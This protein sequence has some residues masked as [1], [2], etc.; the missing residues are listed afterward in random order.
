MIHMKKDMAESYKSMALSGTVVVPGDKS[1]SH[2]AL[3]LGAMAQGI[4]KINGL[5]ESADVLATLEAVKCLGA[6]VQRLVSGQWQVHGVGQSG[7]VSPQKPIECGN[8]GTAVRLLMGAA[9]G[10]ALEAEFAGDISL[11]ARP[12]DRVLVPLQ[13]M[14]VRTRTWREARLPVRLFSNGCLSPIKYNIPHPSAQVKSAILLA[15]LHAQ[16]RSQICE[17]VL[18]R[19]HTENM[20]TAFGVTVERESVGAGQRV[21]VTGCSETKACLQATHVVVPGDPSSAAFAI[22]AALIVPGSEVTV[23]NV[24]MNPTRIGL[25]TCLKEMGANLRICRMRQSGGEPVA[26]I[27]VRHSALKAIN[28]PAM[29]APSMID[30]YPV[31][32]VASAY[33]HGTTVMNGLAELRVKETDRIAATAALLRVNGCV[34]EDSAES[35]AVTGGKVRGGGY[36]ITHHDHRIAMSALVLGLAAEHPVRIDDYGMIATS[37]PNFF[38]LMTDMNACIKCL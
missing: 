35:L 25:L 22:V 24:M 1:I 17:A 6:Q 14:G 26:D 16:G 37:F 27:E 2:R 36:V 3:I 38:T 15:A 30:E 33:A 4:T 18:T 29:R 28:V 21:N 34:I 10:Y 19:D 12:M 32:A 20:L 7:F 5:L 9:A 31:L 13:Q 11:S 23:K 8:S